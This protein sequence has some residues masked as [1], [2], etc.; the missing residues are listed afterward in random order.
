MSK[1][2]EKLKDILNLITIKNIYEKLN[3]RHQ[4]IIKTSNSCDDFNN[5]KHLPILNAFILVIQISNDKTH[6]A[7]DNKKKIIK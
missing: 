7:W 2:R 3:V 4:C 5:Y 6:N 1:L